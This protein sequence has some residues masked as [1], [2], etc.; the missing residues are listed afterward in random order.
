[1]TMTNACLPSQSLLN[2]LDT[3]PL[4]LVSYHPT[5]APYNPRPLMTS[6][7]KELSLKVDNSV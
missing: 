6:D 5:D 3:V 2:N 1:M 4:Q 7:F